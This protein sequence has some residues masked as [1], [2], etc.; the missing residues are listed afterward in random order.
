MFK[1]CLVCA[2]CAM[3]FTACEKQKQASTE[4]G[5]IPKQMIDKATEDLNNARALAVEKL[6]SADSIDA[7]EDAAK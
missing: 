7:P 3:I 6:K 4:V 5:V 2:L 1:L